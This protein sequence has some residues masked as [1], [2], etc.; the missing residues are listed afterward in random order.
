MDTDFEESNDIL[1]KHIIGIS[2]NQSFW[3]SK[4]TNTFFAK[5][6]INHLNIR[7]TDLDWLTGSENVKG[8]TTKNYLGYGVG[9]RFTVTAPFSIKLSYEHSVRLPLARELLGN[10]S[11]IYANVALKPESSDNINLGFFG[12]WHPA[13]GHTIYYE[14][15]GFLRYVDDYIQA[16]VSE[17]EATMQYENVPAV[18][19]K[20]LEGEIRYN[21]QNK[22]QLISNISFEEARDQ[23]RYKTDG[24]P[25][26][27]YNNRVPNRP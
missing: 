12:T 4:L 9:S 17:K 10:G 19:I 14:T 15:S 21:W 24:K 3:D 22:L 27:T 18:H 1:A 6:Y 8:S 16:K 2:Y 25:S 11:T 20:G 13:S 26:A 5:D 23:K 7:Q